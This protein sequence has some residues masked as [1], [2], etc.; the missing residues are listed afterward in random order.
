MP[1]W[2]YADRSAC[3]Q[4][5]WLQLLWESEELLHTLSLKKLLHRLTKRIENKS[6]GF[7]SNGIR[8]EA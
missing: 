5:F 3:P 4:V 6:R 7:D 8:K 1:S 2:R